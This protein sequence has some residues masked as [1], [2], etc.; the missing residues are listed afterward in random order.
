MTAWMHETLS[1][2]SAQISLGVISGAAF[3][4]LAYLL[5]GRDVGPPSMFPL[6]DKVLHFVAFAG[7]TGPAILALP[8]RYWMFWI[9]HMVLVAVGT[10]YFQGLVYDARSASVWDATADIAGIAAATLVCDFIRRSVV[11]RAGG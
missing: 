6:Q 3:A 4:L 7:V 1:A 10:E 2:R 5:M 8:R 9:S 11:A